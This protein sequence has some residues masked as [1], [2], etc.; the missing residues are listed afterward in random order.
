MADINTTRSG[1][2]IIMD[3]ADNKGSVT[4]KD[5]SENLSLTASAEMSLNAED[6]TI[7]G[8]GSLKA[9]SSDTNIM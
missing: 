3:D 9:S 7:S 2:S 4:I 6:I 8:T 1:I 5:P